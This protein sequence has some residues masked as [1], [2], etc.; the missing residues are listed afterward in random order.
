MN[1]MD[2]AIAESAKNLKTGHGGP[3]GAVVVKDGVIVGRGHNEVLKHNDPTCHG[4]IQAIRDACRSLGT[5]DLSGCE[6]YT[7]AE[8]CPMCLSAIIWANI[9]TVYYG[10]S[11]KDAAA[12]GFR[13]DFIYDFIKRGCA[14]EG[15]L[16]LRQ[17]GREEAIKIFEQYKEKNMTIY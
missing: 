11:A 10:N 9:K 4:E 17:M 8:P 15:T 7:S 1:F 12:I 13:D 14:D 6:L 16:A 3:F 2:E 5:Y